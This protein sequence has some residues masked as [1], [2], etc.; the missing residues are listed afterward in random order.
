MNAAASYHQPRPPWASTTSSV[1]KSRTT[2]S[3]YCG[4][5]SSFIEP[6]KLLVPQCT[7][8]GTPRST[9]TWYAGYSAASSHRNPP[10]TGCSFS[11]AAPR[12]SWRR[13]SS[14]IGK[15]R[16]GLTLATGRNRRRVVLHDRQQVLEPL[17]AGRLGAVLAEQQRDGRR[18]APRTARRAGQ[19]G[20]RRCGP[21]GPRGCRRARS[22]APTRS[23]P[24]PASPARAR[25]RARR[26]AG[27][28]PASA[29]PDQRGVGAEV[30]DLAGAARV[31]Q[32][33]V[34]PGEHLGEERLVVRD[35]RARPRPPRVGPG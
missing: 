9:S 8:S 28:R 35:V 14:A 17:V 30:A 27:D 23:T 7:T 32:R 12:S 29:L 1:G 24:A 33:P 19:A 22:R 3:R 20:A 31:A 34:T 13:T 6:G 18:P 2:G 21:R 16:C 11:A 15:C 10:C 25:G 4:S 5:A 26:R